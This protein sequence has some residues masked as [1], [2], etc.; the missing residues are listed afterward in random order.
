MAGR[1]K[2]R[3]NRATGSAPVD[4]AELLGELEVCVVAGPGGVGKTTLAAAIGLGMARRGRRVAVVTIDPAKRLAAALG[5]D[6]LGNAPG[7]VPPARLRAAGVEPSGE[8][9]LWAMT[10]DSRRTFDDLIGRLAPDVKSR[11]RILGNRIYREISG[12]VA[13][14]QEFTAVAKLH[15]LESEGEFDLIVLDTPPSRNALDFLDAP[16]RLSRFFD[17]RA[18]QILMRPAGIGL[19]IAGGGANLVVGLLKR[20]TGATLFSDLAEFFTAINGIT[21]GFS[22]RAHAVADLLEAPT[23][24]FIVVAAPEEGPVDEAIHLAGELEDRGMNPCAVVAN[25]VHPDPGLGRRSVRSAK[26]KDELGEDLSMRLAEAV[27]AAAAAAGRDRLELDRLESGTGV[28]GVM[29]VPRMS[30]DVHDIA[31][32]AII[33]GELF[34]TG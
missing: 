27:D 29:T 34:G 11:D 6:R 16:G 1:S 10:L 5:V 20:V 9:G 31:G 22:E 3:G 24:G 8:G 28:E 32:L 33:E 12:A 18:I 4:L 23:T 26:A 2:K 7:P 14:S 21:A 25:R 13:G 15:E 30:D 19:R 17:G